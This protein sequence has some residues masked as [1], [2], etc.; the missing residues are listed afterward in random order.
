MSE[1]Q[2]SAAAAAISADLQKVLK[3]G[4]NHT[5]EAGKEVYVEHAA[6]ADL[7]EETLV[8]VTEYNR[9]FG[10][11][12][13]DA[14]AALALEAIN[15]DKDLKSTKFEAVVRGVSG[16]E[17]AVSY[18]G[19]KSGVI[20]SGDVEKPWTS[21]GGARLAHKSAASGKR[22]DLGIAMDTAAAAAEAAL[23]AK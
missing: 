4:E 3:F 13:I 2:L 12:M 5:A 17:F 6:K 20:K 19:E 21:Y 9:T 23:S 18:V 11:G 16:E 14:T 15:G 10:A 7:T 8:K 1:K 22:S